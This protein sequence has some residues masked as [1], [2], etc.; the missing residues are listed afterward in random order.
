MQK[1]HGAALHKN[2]SGSLRCGAGHRGRRYIG[3]DITK[4]GARSMECDRSHYVM[5]RLVRA[6]SSSICA[7]IDGPDKSGHDDVGTLSAIA[8]AT[9]FA[10]V[11]EM[12][13]PGRDEPDHDVRDWPLP[14]RR[15]NLPAV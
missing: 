8:Q 2:N 1:S 13:E 10:M 15:P 7:A 4:H 3:A 5:A 6:I 9:D 11:S 14:E 12:C